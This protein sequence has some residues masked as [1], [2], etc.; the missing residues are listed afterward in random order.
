MAGGT[1]ANEESKCRMIRCF[2][3][4]LL[5]S[6][7]LFSQ[8]LDLRSID[9]SVIPSNDSLISKKYAFI[10]SDCNSFQF[11][12]AESPNWTYLHQQMS[13]MIANK[14]RKLNFYH[15]GGSHIQADIYT[16]DFRTFLQSNWPGLNG[17]RG[18]VFPFGLAK[19]NNP[20]NYHFSSPNTW[21]S[22][23]SVNDH[24]D[25][26][27]YGLTGATIRCADSVITINFKHMRTMVKPPFN[28]LRI[29]HNTG[30]FPYEL[31]FGGQELLVSETYH[32]VELGYSEITFTDYI[33]SLDL[34]FVKNTTVPNILEIYGFELL[35]ELPGITYNAIGIN[36][37][38]LYTYL[39]NE[40][41]LRDL[42]IH[43]PD[44]F[45]FS[46][47]T[48]DAY[49][50][51]GN[52]RPEVYKNN[53]ESLMKMIL[54]VNPKCALLL[55]VPNDNQYRGAPNKNTER[56]REVIFQLAQEYQM[57]VWDFYGIMGE[58]GSSLTWRRNS[59]MQGDYV[60]FTSDGYHLKGTLLI[61]AFLKYLAAFDELTSQ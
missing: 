59:L 14:D 17:E 44:M 48:N 45:V 37:A 15:I 40:H 22:Y 60:H 50:S 58:L 23:R 43:P 34:Q 57:A 10:N 11:F 1:G 39:G 28:K 4:L 12:S 35:N 52:F 33:D 5:C 7:A 21:K 38:G 49:T 19:T 47:G 46:V 3:F 31:N 25:D 20:S 13:E 51:F 16:H 6:N 42:K 27:D 29:Y 36:G 8:T 61:D 24:P 2:I 55:T 18:L 30:E 54:S 32:H 56:Q 26:L 9:Y 53:L 41:F